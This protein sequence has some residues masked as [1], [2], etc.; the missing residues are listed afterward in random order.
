M[1]SVLVEHKNETFP[2]QPVELSNASILISDDE[3][4]DELTIEDFM[5]IL[6]KQ[7]ALLGRHRNNDN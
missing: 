6:D 5:R 2:N 4:L 7:D 3:E 1:A